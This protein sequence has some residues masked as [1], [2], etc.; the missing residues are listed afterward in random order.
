VK[1]ETKFSR[2]PKE[3]AP[4]VTPHGAAKVMAQFLDRVAE[5]QWLT[6]TQHLELATTRSELAA[7]GMVG[8]SLN[9]ENAPDIEAGDDTPYTINPALIRRIEWEKYLFACGPV[10]RAFFTETKDKTVGIA[11]DGPEKKDKDFTLALRRRVKQAWLATHDRLPTPEE[12]RDAAL[13]ISY[14]KNTSPLHQA[15]AQ[16]EEDNDPYREGQHAELTKPRSDIGYA[17][18]V[19]SLGLDMDDEPEP[20]YQPEY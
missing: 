10:H 6:D 13:Y 16:I 2:K 20:G 11:Y 15:A 1:C 19:G 12:I 9:D 5:I 18:P 3:D 7:N 14:Y 17:G 8:K 4:L